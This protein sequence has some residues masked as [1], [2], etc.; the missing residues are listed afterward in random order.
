MYDDASIRRPHPRQNKPRETQ[1]HLIL[2]TVCV[3][4]FPYLYTDKFCFDIPER[5]PCACFCSASH[6][7]NQLHSCIA[8]WSCETCTTYSK[9]LY[10]YL[11]NNRNT[12][13]VNRE[14]PDLSQI[15]RDRHSRSFDLHLRSIN[16][17][18]RSTCALSI[19]KV[20][21]NFSTLKRSHSPASN[22]SHVCGRNGRSDIGGLLPAPAREHSIT[23]RDL[24]SSCYL[25]CLTF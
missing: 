12:N 20:H 15:S 21:S 13:Y 1:P 16:T 6:N 22:Y 10:G 18:R 11:R 8:C 23:C 3:R 7:I 9:S 4:R 5:R 2:Q 25:L 19:M 17:H 24:E 14:G